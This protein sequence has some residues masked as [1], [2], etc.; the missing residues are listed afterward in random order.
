MDAITDK[1]RTLPAGILGLAAAASALSLVVVSHQG[2][3]GNRLAIFGVGALA[4]GLFSALA[5]LRP[6]TN[7]VLALVLM[8]SPLPLILTL[9][10]SAAVSVFLLGASAL[11]FALRTPLR[12]IAPDPLLLPVVLFAGY[13]MLCAV[14]GLLAGND[15]AYVAGDAYQLIEFA[16]VYFLASQLLRDVAAIRR[17]LRWVLVSILITIS[18]ELL[19]FILGSDAGGLLP[20]W[21]GASHTESLV[22]T[23]DIDATILFTVLI[24]LYPVVRSP[25]HRR[26]IGVALVVTVANLALSLSRGLWVCAVVAV[27]ASIFLQGR[28]VR[29]R[30]LKISTYGA[31]AVALLAAAWNV[32]SASDGSLMD[33]F[34]E[35]VFHGVDQ[36]EQGLDGTESMATRRFLEMAIVGPQVLAAP[37]LG[38]GLGATYI[39]GGFAVLDAGTGG[40]IDHHFIHNF[41]L[42]T[43]FRMGGIGLGLMLWL[44]F[45]YFRRALAACRKLPTGLSKAL[46][47]GL[48]ASLMGQLLLSITQPTL[49]DHP[50]CILI[51][52]AMALSLRIAPLAGQW[53]EQVETDTAHGI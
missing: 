10:Q 38:H 45:R 17:L 14:R 35:R 20:S 28:K 50:T 41:Y 25:R 8:T 47:A 27:V 2:F 36:V 21:E 23:I 5:Y 42:S 37:W 53:D 43:A 7:F 49:L 13:D 12:V 19:L 30:L 1:P 46:V 44:L 16:L 6:L 31:V 4:L 24:N 18:F 22:R 40:L 34:E 51:A 33:V 3:P 11:G 48:V 39:I 52:A 26:Y 29:T 32:G 9:P 15:A